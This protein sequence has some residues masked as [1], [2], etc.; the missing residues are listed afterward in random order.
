MSESALKGREWNELFAVTIWWIWRWRNDQV[1]KKIEIPI[2]EKVSPMKNYHHELHSILSNHDI[3]S[4]RDD[5]VILAWV[6]WTPPPLIWAK[7]NTDGCVNPSLRTAGGR[8]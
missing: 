8:F 2:S 3:I 4:R 1:F 6:G 7:L 5:S